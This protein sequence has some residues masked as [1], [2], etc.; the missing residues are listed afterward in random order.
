[1]KNFLQFTKMALLI[2]AMMIIFAPNGKAQSYTSF[3]GDNYAGISGVYD[4][5]ASIANSRYIV[6]VTLAGGSLDAYNDYYGLHRRLMLQQVNIFN[7]TKRNYYRNILLNEP[8]DVPYDVEP[9][10]RFVSRN[11]NANSD[12]HYNLNTSMDLQLLNAMVTFNK[13][14]MAIGFTERIRGISTI[15]NVSQNFAD[16]WYW[17]DPVYTYTPTYPIDNETSRYASA[18][19]NEVGITFASQVKDWGRHYLKGGITL[20]FYEG[21]SSYYLITKD[22][23]ID[24]YNTIDNYKN[25]TLNSEGSGKIMYGISKDFNAKYMELLQ[26]RVNNEEPYDYSNVGDIDAFKVWTNEFL[27]SPFDGKFWKNVGIGL[28]LGVVY[29]WR[30]NYKDYV[31]SMDGDTGLTRNDLNKYALKVSLAVTDLIFNG[32]KFERDEALQTMMLEGSNITFTSGTFHDILKMSS[33][34][35][36][37]AIN[38]E[39]GTNTNAT[40]KAA[41]KEY[42]IKL[43]PTLNINADYRIPKSYFYV[44]LGASVPFDAFTGYKV[45]E[46]DNSSYDVVKIHGNTVIS[47]APRYERKWFGVSLPVTFLPDYAEGAGG[48]DNNTYA[49]INVGLGLRLGPVWIGSNTVFTSLM[50]KYW[51]GVDI[52][53]A[54]KVP[55]LYKAPKD[56]DND[57]VSDKLDQ[58]MY[59]PGPWETRGCPDTDGDGIID[60]EDECPLQP[61]L[62]K[63]NGCPDTDGDGIQDKE[64]KC[65]YEAG[66]P[67]FQGCPD[68]DG[69]GIPDYEDKCPDV[70]GV[71]ELQ[72]CPK[73][74]DRDGDGIPDDEDKC[75]DVP[76][77]KKFDGCPDKDGDGI[78]DN[79]DQCPEI[80]G[81]VQNH[82]CPDKIVKVLSDNSIPGVNF[83]INKSNVK[84]QYFAE[85]DDF[86]NQIKSCAHPKIHIVGHTDSTGND[87]IN[88]PLSIRRAKAVEQYLI[89]KGI[90]PSIITIDGKG[91]HQ[92]IATNKTKEGRA[93]NR[94][95]EIEA[96]FN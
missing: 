63:F 52:C 51:N 10:D 32:I 31:Y 25:T 33:E 67:Q 23:D 96:T 22:V 3:L 73:I 70:P 81:T 5:P 64:D 48:G 86:A 37:T 61:G 91:S 74:S 18:T 50:E 47:L 20:K 83:D 34:E 29:E 42:K 49:P 9:K 90:D 15:D 45:T 65:P 30:P 80:F 89:N 76:G 24:V 12:K 60:S 17:E 13:N 8:W 72:G 84:P 35:I 1:M 55:I 75:P 39:F 82:G 7:R 2:I 95:V 40:L 77:L 69:D 62:A 26:K 87:A 4:N 6:D 44:N 57:G 19:W 28:D 11:G 21:L 71:K 85:L 59:I 79:E 53:A 54:V 93:K 56:I 92:P 38:N 43:S 88:D 78:P 14:K 94:R 27:N 41:S 36:N 58:C 66:L 46:L 16:M 68:R